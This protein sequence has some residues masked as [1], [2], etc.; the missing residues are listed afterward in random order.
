[1]V[2]LRGGEANSPNPASGSQEAAIRPLVGFTADAVTAFNPLR[3]GLWGVGGIGRIT[4]IR[5]GCANVCS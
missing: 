2:W 1:M 3:V 5:C 4:V